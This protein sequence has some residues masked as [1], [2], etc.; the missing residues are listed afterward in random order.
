MA[1]KK[2]P[3]VYYSTGWR[4]QH[5]DYVRVTKNPEGTFFFGVLAQ[6][7]NVAG[8]LNISASTFTKQADFTACEFRAALSKMIDAQNAKRRKRARRE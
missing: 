4:A 8:R 5:D 6:D 2:T 7:E 3:G 1:K